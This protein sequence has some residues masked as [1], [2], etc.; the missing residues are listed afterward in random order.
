LSAALGLLAVG[1]ARAD[2]PPE[3]PLGAELF[4]DNDSLAV[5]N[6]E[7]GGPAEKAGLKVGDVIVRIND[8]VVKEKGLTARDVEAAGNEILKH[9]PGDKIKLTVKRAG[10]EHRLTVTVGK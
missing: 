3:D 10:K 5:G 4:I 2:D 9:K 6:V 7:P 8:L 1:A